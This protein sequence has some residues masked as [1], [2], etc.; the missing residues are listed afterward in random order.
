MPDDDPNGDDNDDDEY[1]DDNDDAHGNDDIVED[2]YK[3]LTDTSED[4]ETYC[5]PDQVT[6]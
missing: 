3:L 4:G 6:L 5:T 1:D 2:F